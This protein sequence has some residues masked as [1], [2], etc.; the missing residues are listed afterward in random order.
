MLARIVMNSV[1]TGPSRSFRNPKVGNKPFE[2]GYRPSHPGHDPRSRSSHCICRRDSHPRNVWVVRLHRTL[3][4]TK[5]NCRRCKRLSHHSV[6]THCTLCCHML[7]LATTKT[8]ASTL[9]SGPS[10]FHQINWE[11][12][13]SLQFQLLSSVCASTKAV[14]RLKEPELQMPPSTSQ[15]HTIDRLQNLR[16]TEVKLSLAN[17]NGQK[18]L[19]NDARL[20]QTCI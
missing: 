6:D 2:T 17:S 8:T 4:L 10:Y 3:P 14:K 19:P 11:R 18:R 15:P 7:N 12:T 13:P 9:K 16:A 1:T 20:R 5:G